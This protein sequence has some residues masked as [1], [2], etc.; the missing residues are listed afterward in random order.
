MSVYDSFPE[1]EFLS[2]LEIHIDLFG[3]EFI[4]SFPKE[5]K[6]SYFL[7]LYCYVLCQSVMIVRVWCVVISVNHGII[8]SVLALPVLVHLVL[9]MYVLVL[10]QYGSV[11]HAN[12][13]CSFLLPCHV[14]NK[15]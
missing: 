11:L 14:L 2:D 7:I 5:E 10:Q 9:M 1:K 12:L 4:L 8:L 6:C 3:K 13:E 15:N